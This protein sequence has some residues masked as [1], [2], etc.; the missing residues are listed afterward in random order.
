MAKDFGRQDAEVRIRIAIR[1]RFT[2]LGTPETHAHASD[3]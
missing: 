3:E 2:A 1:N